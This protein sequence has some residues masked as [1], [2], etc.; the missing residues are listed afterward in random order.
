LQFLSGQFLPLVL[1]GNQ[2]GNEIQGPMASVILGGLITA[3]VLNMIVVP[4][5]FDWYFSSKKSGQNKMR[6]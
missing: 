2:P 3:T 6:T 4:L 1:T 5:L